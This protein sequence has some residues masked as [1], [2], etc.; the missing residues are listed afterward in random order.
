[1]LQKLKKRNCKINP[2]VIRSEIKQRQEKYAINQ[3]V[4]YDKYND[5]LVFEGK[6]LSL[7]LSVLFAILDYNRQLSQEED[8]QFLCFFDV[9]LQRA[10]AATCF[11]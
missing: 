11:Q 7:T 9:L 4:F 8:Q 3:L 6:T 2:E 5:F 10:S 1:M